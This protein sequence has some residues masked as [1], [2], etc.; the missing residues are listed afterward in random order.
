[1][2]ARG[3]EVLGDVLVDWGNRVEQTLHS[4]DSIQEDVEIDYTFF[5]CWQTVYHQHKTTDRDFRVELFYCAF[6]VHIRRV[7]RTLAVS[8]LV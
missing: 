5:V 2:I 8:F 3:D 1:M 6:S 7:E 4:T